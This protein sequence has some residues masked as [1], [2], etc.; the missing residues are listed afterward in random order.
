MVRQLLAAGL[1]ALALPAHAKEPIVGDCD[2]NGTVTISDLMLGVQEAETDCTWLGRS[3]CPCEALLCFGDIPF[4]P[5]LF[6]IQCL[7]VA[8]GNALAQ[9]CA[10]TVSNGRVV[11]EPPPP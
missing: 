8:V 7:E 11:C 1:L 6:P 2:G 10:G 9:P 4:L 3:D 5:P